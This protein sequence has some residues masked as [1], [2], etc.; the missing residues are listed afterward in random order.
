MILFLLWDITLQSKKI[1][2]PF[3]NSWKLAE[4]SKELKSCTRFIV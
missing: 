2:S 3:P 4:K 1:P